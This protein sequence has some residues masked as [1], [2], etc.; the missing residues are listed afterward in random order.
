[1]AKPTKKDRSAEEVLSGLAGQFE[2]AATLSLD[3]LLKMLKDPTAN[4]SLI[5]LANTS[6]IVADRFVEIQEQVVALKRLR[7]DLA[8]VEPGS[9]EEEEILANY[10]ERQT[11]V[12]TRQ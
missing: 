11:Q 2:E 10:K 7:N 1:M 6:K 5:S 9:P 4:H 8:A 12:H 3:L